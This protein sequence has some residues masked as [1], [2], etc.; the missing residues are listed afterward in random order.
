MVAEEKVGR[1]RSRGEKVIDLLRLRWLQRRISLRLFVALLKLALTTWPK[2]RDWIEFALTGVAFAI[3]AATVGFM[4]GLLHMAPRSAVEIVRV[5]AIALLAPGLSE[6]LVFRGALIPGRGERTSG[7]AWI[8]VSTALF[9]LWHVIETAF[10]P[11]GA[12]FFRRVDF[13]TLAALL[14]LLCGFLRWR[15]GSLWPAVALHWLA[16]VAWIGWFGGPSLTELR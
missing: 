5:A 13:L 12:A 4:S 11:G 1:F 8:V 16:A 6:E 2:T 7:F 9:A 14:G 15:S 10:L 3:A